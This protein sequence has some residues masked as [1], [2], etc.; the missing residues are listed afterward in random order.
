MQAQGFLFCESAC[1]NVADST[2]AMLQPRQRALP[3]SDGSHAHG[4]NFNVRICAMTS[5]NS[6]CCLCLQLLGS[7]IKSLPRDDIIVCTRLASML[8]VISLRG[9]SLQ[10][11]GSAPQRH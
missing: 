8:Q 4:T 5:S 1:L 2:F 10:P 9:P 7:A 3:V 6:A 11:L